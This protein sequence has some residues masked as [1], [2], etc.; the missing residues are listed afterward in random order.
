MAN[1]ATLMWETE[2]PIPFTCADGTGIEKGTLLELSDPMTVAAH[3]NEEGT[4]GGIAAEEKIANDGHTKISVY[5]AG[6]FK[7]TAK[8]AITVGNALALSDTANKVKAAD[9]TCVGAD[10]IGVALETAAD[11]ET[12]MAEIRPGFNNN[13]YA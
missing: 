6:I 4:F 9:A 7:L 8:G 5:R 13:A 12:F 10:I 3:S 11:G 2:L 1:E